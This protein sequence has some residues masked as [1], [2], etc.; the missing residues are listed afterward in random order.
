VIETT[1]KTQLWMGNEEPSPDKIRPIRNDVEAA[2]ICKPK[3]GLWT[4]TYSPEF[5]SDWYQYLT[6][7]G[8][9]RDPETSSYYL[10]QPKEARVLV[11]DG[12]ES[13]RSL[14]E[15]YGISAMPWL[16]IPALK[17]HLNKLTINPRSLDFEEIAETYDAIHLTRKGLAATKSYLHRDDASSIIRE[18][19][20]VGMR[21][22]DCETV[23][24]LRWK[25]SGVTQVAKETI[26]R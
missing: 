23:L 8:C 20:A 17:E 15:T 9:V 14:F 2:V 22:W 3:G 4:S 19:G 13:L 5:G 11:V 18:L 6:G 25:F 7:V 16:E 10:L 21:A 24:W 26:Q 1:L 12:L